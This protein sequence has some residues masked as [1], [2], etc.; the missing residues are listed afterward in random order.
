MH[1]QQLLEDMGVV[2]E[3]VP[4]LVAEL[5]TPY[6]STAIPVEDGYHE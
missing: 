4:T 3:N 1:V 6:A 2:V 5:Q